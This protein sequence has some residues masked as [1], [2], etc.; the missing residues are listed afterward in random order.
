[1]LQWCQYLWHLQGNAIAAAA[2]ESLVADEASAAAKAAAKKAKKQKAK[3]RKQQARS[4]VTSASPPPASQPAAS[5]PAAS[6]PAASQVPAS[7]PAASEVPASQPSAGA[8]L[9]TQ[10]D[11]ET[12]A[13]VYPTDSTGHRLLPDQQHASLPAQL[14][15]MTVQGSV[16]HTLPVHV[17]MDEQ[18]PPSAAAAAGGTPA[19]NAAAVTASQ[20]DDASFLDQLF[21][22]PITKVLSSSYPSVSIPIPYFSP[23]SPPHLLLP[24]HPAVP[25]CLSPL[26]ALAA[27][28][29]RIL[30]SMIWA[31]FCAF[32]ICTMPKVSLCSLQHL[33]T[34][35]SHT[36]IQP[37][38]IHCIFG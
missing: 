26:S 9:Q 14:H 23:P 25:P 38:G 24:P 28:S 4:D 10:Q 37:T 3:A 15:C 6:Q 16:T 21:C 34:R 18:E 30:S 7:Q 29:H 17:A 33:V 27:I 19:G 13:A 1:M 32:K 36:H 35:M 2:A 31:C 12:T 8:S 5:Q 22:C 20:R 11:A